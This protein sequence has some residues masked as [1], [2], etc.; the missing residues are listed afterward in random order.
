MSATI[1]CPHCN[2]VFRRRSMLRQHMQSH[3]QG[4]PLMCDFCG[5]S[6]LRSCGLKHHIQT[7]HSIENPSKK[8]LRTYRSFHRCICEFCGLKFR[9]QKALSRH[10]A[11][12]HSDMQVLHPEL[13]MDEVPSPS[14][15][16]VIASSL[17][18]ILM[19]PG[20]TFVP[21]ESEIPNE[22]VFYAELTDEPPTAGEE[23]IYVYTTVDDQQQLESI[24]VETQDLPE[25]VIETDSEFQMLE[26][27]SSQN[28]IMIMDHVPAISDTDVSIFY[29]PETEPI[30]SPD[31][32]IDLGDGILPSDALLHDDQWFL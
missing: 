23:V 29:A 18:E 28:Q 25:L 6:Y 11:T 30:S 19:S 7:M 17:S 12:Q 27:I 4:F 24:P 22:N 21:E 31:V 10:Y 2:M 3:S 13:F 1:P 8:T 5:R 9:R 16:D 26:D 15:P 20:Q 14:N 32:I